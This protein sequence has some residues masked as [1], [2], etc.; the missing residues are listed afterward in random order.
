MARRLYWLDDHAYTTFRRPCYVRVIDCN[1]VPA[2]RSW[3]P[4]GWEYLG[5]PGRVWWL[6]RLWLR[7][8]GWSLLRP[9]ASRERRAEKRRVR[10][11]RH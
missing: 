7:V 8:K 6:R 1:F 3:Q 4:D 10:P 2:R 11:K 5:I 9:A